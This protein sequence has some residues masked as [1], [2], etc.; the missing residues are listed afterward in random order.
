MGWMALGPR[1][2]RGL[3][4]EHL[5]CV[6]GFEFGKLLADCGR[7]GQVAVAGAVDVFRAQ[8]FARSQLELR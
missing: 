3:A 2:S 1:S 7:V 4:R 6:R 5:V 8:V